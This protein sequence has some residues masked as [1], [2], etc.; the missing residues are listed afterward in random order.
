MNEK[1]KE[2]VMLAD[3]VAAPPG[4]LFLET[5]DNSVVILPT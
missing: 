1:A 4:E 5:N 2:A 3:V